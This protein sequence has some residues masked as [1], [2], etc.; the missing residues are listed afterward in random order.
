MC[1]SFLAV[2]K[3]EKEGVEG[4]GI[5]GLAHLIASFAGGLAAIFNKFKTFL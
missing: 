1:E 5:F 2:G 3:P 4:E